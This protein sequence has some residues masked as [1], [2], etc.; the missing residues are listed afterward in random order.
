MAINKVDGQ[1][2]RRNSLQLYMLESSIKTPRRRGIYHPNVTTHI[3]PCIL[4]PIIYV[5]YLDIVCDFF[6]SNTKISIYVDARGKLINFMGDSCSNT[7]LTS[8][9]KIS[10]KDDIGH[11]A[12]IM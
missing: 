8:K 1:G 7:S 5:L 9:L 4:P 3:S 6:Y 11:F 12:L 2:R 10:I